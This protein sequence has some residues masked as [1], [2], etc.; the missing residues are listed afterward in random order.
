MR[1]YSQANILLPNS[2]IKFVTLFYKYT[3]GWYKEYLQN[4]VMTTILLLMLTP[5]GL[6]MFYFVKLVKFGNKIQKIITFVWWMY[7]LTKCS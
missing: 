6:F 2:Y 7:Y 5:M 3:I 1:T 4:Q